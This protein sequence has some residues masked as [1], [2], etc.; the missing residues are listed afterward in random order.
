[1]DKCKL[2]DGLVIKPDG[3]NELDPCLYR[4]A[5][6]HKNVTVK[7]YE[8]TRCGAIDI[9]WERQENTEDVYYEEDET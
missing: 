4:L 5:E 1:M 2:P 7:V 6:V 9:C 3:L 8:C